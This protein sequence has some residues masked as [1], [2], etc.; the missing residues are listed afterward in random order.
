MSLRFIYGR[1]GSGKTHFC[2]DELKTKIIGGDQTPFVLLVPEQY[3]F[4]AERDLIAMLKTGGILKTEVLSFQRLAFRVFNE[5]GGITYPHMHP[6]GKNMLLYRILDRMKGKLNIFNRSAEQPGFV[7]T[8]STLITEFKRYNVTPRK[9][10]TVVQNMNEDSPLKEKLMELAG[11]Y[12]SFDELVQ[13]RYRDPDDDLTLAAQKLKASSQ[14][15]GAEI[16]ID[17]FTDF[18]PQEYSIIQELLHQAKRVT[19]TLT[20]DALDSETSEMD[21]FSSAKKAYQ[22]LLFLSRQDNIA[23]EPPVRLHQKP[24]YRFRYSPELFHLE[25]NLNAHPYRVYPEPTTQISLFSNMNIFTEIESAAT[26]ILRLCRDEGF[27]F[28]D[29][30]VVTRN[31]KAYEKLIEVIFTEFGIPSFLDRKLDII[32][33]PLVRLILSMLEI[34]SENW[35]YESVFGYLK[36]GLTGIEQSR[37]DQL[38]NYVLA[39]GIRGGKWTAKEE[40]NM[41]PELL[42][43]ERSLK[44]DTYGLKEINRTRMVLIAPLQEFRDRTKGRRT[45]AE[46]CTALFDFLCRLKIPERMEHLVDAF[47]ETGDLIRA[48][49][50][51]QVWNI[52]MAL[53][54]QMVE[55]MADD[56]FGVERF[57]NLLAIGF[58]EFKIGLIPVSLDQVLVGSVERS[59]SHAI[60]AL[61]ILGT[62]DG[63]FPANGGDEGIITDDERSSLQA[64]GMEL[65][66][67]SRAKAYDE[68]FLVYRT[69]TTPSDYLRISWP[70]ADQEGKGLRPSM[71]INRL[72]KL[73]PAIREKSN[74]LPPDKD[75]EIMEQIVSGATAFRS[76]T[77]A[78]RQKADGREILPVWQDVA[79]W[80]LQQEK[81]K[82]P[83]SIVRQAFQYSNLAKP[84][85]QQKLA[86]LY[87]NPVISSVSKLERY[88]ACPFSF[89][90]QYGLDA[91]ERKIFDMKPPDVGTFLHAAIERFSRMMNHT[92]YK[93]ADGEDTPVTWRNFS[94]EW[95]EQKVSEIVDDSLKSMKGS[96][97]SSSKHFTA[98]TVRLKR[99]VTRAVW[100]IAEHIRRSGFNPMD[101][102]VGFGE[103]EKYPPIVIEMDSGEKVRLMGRI[104]RIDA[105]ETENGQYLRIIDYKSGSKDFK[106]SNVFYGLQLQLITYMDAIWKDAGED[107]AHPLLPGG[108]LYFRVDDPIIR[109]DGEIDEEEIEKAIMKQL[110][111]K[112]LLLADVKLIKS[113]DSEIDGASQ[114]L[115]ATLN[116]G[117][118]LG[119]N[120][121]VATMEQFKLLRNYTRQLL[122]DISRE[123]ISG[124]VTIHP[125]KNKEGTACRYCSYLS[126]CQFDTTMK[127]NAYHVLRDRNNDETWQLITEAIR[128][129]QPE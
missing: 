31:L 113:M 62:N 19:I 108:M 120:S 126:I 56:T 43:D 44:S 53:L 109:S 92:H 5:E 124:T 95:C 73:F 52:V 51:S 66:K 49:E 35:S 125:V 2:L 87:G 103:G 3:S 8:L 80:F 67:S 57:S 17:G 107:A 79:R 72:R 47:H 98:L 40:W 94:R 32:G 93:S 127:D 11:I 91:K 46:F 99:V 104:D 77:A 22:K 39:C 118:V 128:K 29:I 60:K 70:I 15:R 112:G 76:L 75:A 27:R 25:Q 101:Y 38:E 96:G 48:N 18:T 20:T 82:E 21:L 1:A 7:G 111:M 116:K 122:K 30:A 105:M 69:V 36:S 81:W 54:D 59:K 117:D 61:Y 88:T 102:E 97:I 84:V 110:K 64:A 14:Y 10:D 4:Q 121:S 78:L 55:V 34:F 123:I 33:H 58:A 6:A 13:Q 89:F 65:A 106:L 74:L 26:D 41:I 119:K 129:E 12:K 83:F 71:V 24:L 90:I 45:A 114:I 63:V 85:M 68:N 28:R 16:W 9:L 50:T 100:L 23:Y 86:E 37:I 42:P 115:P